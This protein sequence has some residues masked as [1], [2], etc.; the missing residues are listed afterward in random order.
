M[1]CCRT[2][3]A[4]LIM[5]HQHHAFVIVIEAVYQPY[6][7]FLW[8]LDSAACKV[9][10]I[11]MAMSSGRHRPGTGVITSNFPGLIEF[12]ITHQTMAALL[13]ASGMS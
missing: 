5:S 2:Y 4:F 13:G 1:L 10:R 8:I 11:S 9:A 6:Y 12:D 3:P 7:A